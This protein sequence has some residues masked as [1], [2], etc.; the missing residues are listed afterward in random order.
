MRVTL[1]T[2]LDTPAERAWIEVQT[3][4]LLEHVAAPLL[5]FT[6][7]DPQAL[8]AEWVAGRY[9]VGVRLFGWLPLG[10]QWIVTTKASQGPDC[11]QIRDNGRGTLAR[12]WDH[13]IAIEP[14][15]PA[16][17]RYRDDIEVQAGLLTPFVWAFARF[18]YAHRQR[19]WRRLVARGFDYTRY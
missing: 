14:L 13:L 4:R 5:V 3:A 1:T 10:T 19:R 15:A 7:I 2:L 6:P 17:C 8:P 18:F 12:R 11:Y 9:H 16:R